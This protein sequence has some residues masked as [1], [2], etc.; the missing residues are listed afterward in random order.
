MMLLFVW[1]V[2]DFPGAEE[3]DGKENERANEVFNQIVGF[4]AVGMISLG[5]LRC[6][7]LGYCQ[8]KLIISLYY[9][10]KQHYFVCR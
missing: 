9:F 4:H 1:P 8:V 2:I 10:I 6:Y 5:Y 3:N 7:P